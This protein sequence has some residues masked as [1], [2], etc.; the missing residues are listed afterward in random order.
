MIWGGSI[1][2]VPADSKII[3]I[4]KMLKIDPHAQLLASI[5]SKKTGSWKQIYSYR[6]TLWKKCKSKFQ[7]ST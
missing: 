7:R 2:L 3:R 1:E 5:L 4:E 6:Y